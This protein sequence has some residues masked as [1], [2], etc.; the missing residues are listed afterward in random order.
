M[1]SL[2]GAVAWPSC[3]SLAA[4][5]EAYTGIGRTTTSAR[6]PPS[7]TLAPTSHQRAAAKPLTHSAA[8]VYRQLERLARSWEHPRNASIP[9]Y[10]TVA[11]D[12]RR[13]FWTEAPR[14]LRALQH[15]HAKT[16]CKAILVGH[17]FGGRLLYTTLARFGAQAAEL[18]A[19]ALYATSP[20]HGG[21]TQVAC[22]LLYWCN[23]ALRFASP[24]VVLAVTVGQSCS[25][26][27]VTV[28]LSVFRPC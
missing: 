20:F 2:T 7:T 11:Y 1:D 4:N 9:M 26:C 22:A 21:A 3:C 12:W 18:V 10:Y 15:V 19:G 14:V 24:C 5:T 27:H 13:D 8:Q 6:N 17:S 28:L 25:D 23:F 16:G